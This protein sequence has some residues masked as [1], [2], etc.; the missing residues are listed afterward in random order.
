MSFLARLGGFLGL[1]VVSTLMICCFS[2]G[3]FMRN[4]DKY[5]DF[6]WE[7]CKYMTKDKFPYVQSNEPESDY[8]CYC[9]YF[10]FIQPHSLT[11]IFVILILCLAWFSCLG[12]CVGNKSQNSQTYKKK[13]VSFEWFP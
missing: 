9:R 13:P 3:D 6:K 11:P 10:E 12:L 1:I 7:H 5:F 8:R 4:E 2:C